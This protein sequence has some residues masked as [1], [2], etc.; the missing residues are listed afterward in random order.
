MKEEKEKAKEERGKNKLSPDY[1]LLLYKACISFI[2][3]SN[4]FLNCH[5]F[6]SDENLKHFI[7]PEIIHSINILTL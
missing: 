5:G 4:N 7:H 2:A 6:S 1:K 3:L